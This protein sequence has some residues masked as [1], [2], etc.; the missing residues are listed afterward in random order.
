MRRD[1]IINLQGKFMS[2]QEQPSTE[3]QTL[4]IL[5]DLGQQLVN[6]Q[7]RARRW[8]VFFRIILLSLFVG[9]FAMTTF[10]DKDNSMIEISNRIKNHIALIEIF[11]AIGGEEQVVADDI[12]KSL[13]SAYT[14]PKTVAVILRINSP[15]GSPVHSSNIYNEIIKLKH[16]YTDI[17]IFTVIDDICASGGYY[18]ASATDEIYANQ[19]SL[20]GSI[21]VVS[22]GFGFVDA[23][24]K[25]GITRR[26][27][28]SGENKAFLDPFS[29]VK[30]SQEQHWQNTLNTIHNQF[31]NDVKQ[32]RTKKLKNNPI[33]FSG[34]IWAGKDALEYGLIDGFG[35]CNYV[36]RHI[37]GVESIIDF[38]KK[39]STLEKLF[40]EAKM[41]MKSLVFKELIVNKRLF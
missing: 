13:N 35:D 29:E 27:Y 14:N 11:G 28:T 8:R 15:G 4:K 17:P 16:K 7:R 30:Q 37:V 39:T 6:E 36:A 40:K 21:G 33:I 32:G 38:T 34:M 12:I 41:Q 1:T 18:I 31:I 20:V 19:S 5:A 9:F 23:I 2:N 26:L 3:K 24:E 10:I 25:L 22:S